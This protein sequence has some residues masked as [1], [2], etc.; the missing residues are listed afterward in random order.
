M[1]ALL[2]PEAISERI[3]CSQRCEL[4]QRRVLAARPRFHQ[5]V[6]DLGVDDRPA[7]GDFRDRGCD[8]HAVV[9]AL[10]EQVCASGGS[11]FEPSAYWGSLYWL[12]TTTPIPGALSLSAPAR[13]MPSSVWSVAGGCR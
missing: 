11:G 3:W 10:L 12:N 7:R 2:L 8:L 5:G 9:H 13:R 1:A 4:G 6:D